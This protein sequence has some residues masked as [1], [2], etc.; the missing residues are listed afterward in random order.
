MIVEGLHHG[1][2]EDYRIVRWYERCVRDVLVIR[3]EER[4]EKVSGPNSE[5]KVGSWPLCRRV[6]TNSA[7]SSKGPASH[8]MSKGGTGV[9]VLRCVGPMAITESRKMRRLM[10]RGTRSSKHGRSCSGRKTP[11]TN[12][13]HASFTA[14]L[15]INFPVHCMSTR[16][17][18]RQ[19][20][21]RWLS[22]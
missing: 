18:E 19:G 13:R 20:R 11:A 22:R 14:N 7:R 9:Q 17:R 1:G 5:T 21:W 12:T 16:V 3:E 8:D 10:R 4:P 6:K 15:C 2:L